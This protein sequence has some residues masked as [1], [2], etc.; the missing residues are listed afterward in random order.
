MNLYISSLDRHMTEDDLRPY[1]EKFGLVKSIRI[2]RDADTKESLCYGFVEMEDAAGRKA[3]SLNGTTIKG[4]DIRV[5]IAKPK[6]SKFKMPRFGKFG[7]K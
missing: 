1:F 6:E 7:P 5:N 2:I 4:T 3:L